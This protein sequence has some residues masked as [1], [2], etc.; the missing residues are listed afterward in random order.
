VAK[1][2]WSGSPP[3]HVVL[4]LPACHEHQ[5][6]RRNCE[7]AT[8]T[9]QATQPTLDHLRPSYSVHARSVPALRAA[10]AASAGP[11]AHRWCRHIESTAPQSLTTNPLQQVMA[12]RHSPDIE[13]NA[14]WA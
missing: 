6:Q 3:G 9:A 8:S 13:S 5:V 14:S 11:G 10:A 12:S 2:R 7:L 4:L 1:S